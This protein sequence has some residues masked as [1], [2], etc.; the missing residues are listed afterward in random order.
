[1]SSGVPDF[2]SLS[3]EQQ[4]AVAERLLLLKQS[5]WKPFWCPDPE[6][7]GNPHPLLDANGAI[8]Y[9]PDS[10]VSTDERP[11]GDLYVD[12]AFN[13]RV[14]LD[15]KNVEPDEEHLGRVLLDPTWAHNHARVDQ[16]LPP[17]G[18]AWTLFIMS[19]RGTGKT[20]TGVEFVTL[21]ARK[22]LDGAILG[23]RGTELVNTHVKTLIE[24]AHPEF[25]PQFWASKDLLEW[26]NGAITY[27]F[28]AEK[29][30][31]I[32]SVNLSYAWVD[33]AAWM[34]EIE[35]AWSN[36]RLATRVKSPGNPIHILITSTP[37]PTEWTMKM[38]DDPKIEIRRVSTYA[39]KQNLDDDFIEQLEADFEGTRIGQQELHGVVLRDVVG[40][41]WNDGMFQH[42]KFNEHGPLAFAAFQAFLET[43]SDRVLAIDPAGSKGPRSD[44]T[45]IIGVGVDLYD[46]SGKATL[47]PPF[48]V[49]C[50][51]TLK[52][53]PTEW[54]R[55]AFKAARIIR[56]TKI[57]AEKNFGGDMVMQVLK[58]FAKQFPEE[59]LTP[60][61]DSYADLIEVV[62]A[63]EGKE[64]RAE[65][66]VGKY[67]QGRVIHA[68]GGNE[69]GD[70]GELEKEQTIWVPKSRGGKHPSPNRVDALV[71]A[72][73]KL[74]KGVR[75][76]TNVAN[77]EVLNRLRRPG[78]APEPEPEVEPVID[79]V[80]DLLSLTQATTTPTGMTLLDCY[81]CGRHIVYHPARVC[82]E[83][84][85]FGDVTE[86]ER[87]LLEDYPD[88]GAA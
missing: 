66:T 28:S 61:G 77:R 78:D 13:E 63:Q 79:P 24:H 81:G 73:R 22:G 40:A 49:L 14:V 9:V 30:E 17:W 19:G 88:S 37:R 32:R 59:A 70:L 43:L 68:I 72:V 34:D 41:L 4:R 20:R 42:K 87:R 6:C 5:Q 2:N 64:T 53:S 50:D 29:P 15:P 45:G 60:D 57:V 25:V 35:K 67:E 47:T 58:D 76:A 75:F 31:N 11:I 83:C 23:R 54:A 65:G 18:V 26:P 85:I 82:T 80:R 3:E 33:E 21:C 7:S 8:T 62:H 69:F 39:N 10:E 1:M 86:E 74:E 36:L 84:L 27:L 52:G 16:R 44:A 48:Y 46:E 12:S 55:Q 71:W 38:E 56:A 51:A